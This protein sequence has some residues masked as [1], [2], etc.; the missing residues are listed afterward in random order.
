MTSSSKTRFPVP[1]AP[2]P[3]CRTPPTNELNTELIF[4]VSFGASDTH[5]HTLVSS[6][7]LCCAN[8]DRCLFS[9]PTRSEGVLYRS[10][11]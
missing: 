5:M 8:R 4:T 11:D 1:P 10:R 6:T 3:L 2:G 7:P 9:L